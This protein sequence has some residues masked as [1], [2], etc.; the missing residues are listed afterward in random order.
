MKDHPLSRGNSMGKKKESKKSSAKEDKQ[1]EDN[2]KIFDTDGK[3][4]LQTKQIEEPQLKDT[5]KKPTKAKTI[6]A[7]EAQKLKRAA[8]RKYYSEHKENYKQWNKNWR[9]KQKKKKSE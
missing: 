6:S 1:V 8:W 2:N 5:K 7:E 4:I 3:L 9:E